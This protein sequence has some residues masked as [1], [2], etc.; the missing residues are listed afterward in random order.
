MAPLLAHFALLPVSAAPL[1][2]TTPFAQHFAVAPLRGHL[3]S[4]ARK[5]VGISKESE[6]SFA[7]IT[8]LTEKAPDRVGRFRDVLAIRVVQMI[9]HR[10]REGVAEE[11]V[12]KA[13]EERDEGESE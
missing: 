2:G 1:P 7:R 4:T 8:V 5:W 3:G 10:L 6:K 12:P 11:R 13:A 9:A